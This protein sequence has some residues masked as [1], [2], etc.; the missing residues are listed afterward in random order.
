M[1]QAELLTTLDSPGQ[2]TG[3]R[4]KADRVDRQIKVLG[5]SISDVTMA[6][7]LEIVQAMLARRGGPASSVFFVNAHTLNLAASEAGYRR[8]LNSAD[9]VFG[10][11]PGVRWA[12]RLQGARLHDNV[13]GTDLT[14][15]LLRAAA[16]RG[17]RCFLLGSDERSV[18]KAAE[19]VA[20]TFPGW[21]VAGYH[22][23][24]LT[25]PERDEHALEAINGSEADLLL[26]GMGNPLQ[27]QWI[28]HHRE[29][30]VVPVCMAVGGL[31]QYWAGS[32]S[33]APQWLRGSGLEWLG[34]MLQQPKKARRY[35][36]GN[37]L[38]LARIYNEKWRLR[39]RRRHGGFATKALI[40]QRREIGPRH[41]EVDGEGR[42]NAA[43]EGQVDEVVGLQ[44][45]TLRHQHDVGVP[46]PNLVVRAG[47]FPVQSTAQLESGG[48]QPPAL[49]A[50]EHYNLP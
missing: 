29:R 13:N 43:C 41:A 2:V 10:D 35:L 32:L 6:R 47:A 34:I 30:L 42:V 4:R 18:E 36:I 28:H 8:V 33:R 48:H 22:H 39:R 26:V 40:L 14:P 20:E 17:Y 11:G 44:Q 46:E 19:H 45:R 49:V 50:A 5:V 21:T 24:Y 27:E 16:G 37:P 12:A 7:A 15:A 1:S 38:F 25:T 9:R 23:G 3:H 31:F